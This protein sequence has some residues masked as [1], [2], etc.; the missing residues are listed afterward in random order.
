MDAAPAMDEPPE[1]REDISTASAEPMDPAILHEYVEQHGKRVPHLY[2][3]LH[4]A[5][6]NWHG[7]FTDED[8]CA[9]CLESLNSGYTPNYSELA[10]ALEEVDEEV[11]DPDLTAVDG[12]RF[13]IVYDWFGRLDCTVPDTDVN[14]DGN[15]DPFPLIPHIGLVSR[16]NDPRFLF[17]T[18]ADDRILT[19]AFGH[20]YHAVCLEVEINSPRTED[21]VFQDRCPQCRRRLFADVARIDSRVLHYELRCLVA[22][23]INLVNSKY[24]PRR[25]D[26]S[27]ADNGVMRN[28]ETGE[29]FRLLRN[30]LYD[31]GVDAWKAAEKAFVQGDVGRFSAAMDEAERV[32]DELQELEQSFDDDSADEADVQ[33]AGN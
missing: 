13:H 24:S 33:D 31:R 21:R 5:K 16:A 14:G 19:C 6:R 27:V 10:K 4:T 18:F 26:D 12:S 1:A 8:T 29:A 2:H 23:A 32:D 22:M 3:Y 28:S 17:P 7:R 20:A 15:D 9:I 11:I 25:P 30:Q